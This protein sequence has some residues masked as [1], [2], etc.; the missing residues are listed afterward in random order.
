M[1]CKNGYSNKARITEAI[2]HCKE[3]SEGEPKTPRNL[4]KV[5]GPVPRKMVKLT[6]D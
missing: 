3:L 6:Q 5:L 4:V 1:N 2:S